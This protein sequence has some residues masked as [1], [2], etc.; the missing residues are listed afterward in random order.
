MQGKIRDF[1]GG[2]KSPSLGEHPLLLNDDGFW[3]MEENWG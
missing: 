3:K 2:T 1:Q